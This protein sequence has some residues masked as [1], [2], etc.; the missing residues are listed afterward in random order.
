MSEQNN[1]IHVIQ[2]LM[3]IC[4]YIR[5]REDIT[6]YFGEMDLS[7]YKQNFF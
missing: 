1:F 2:E 5:L 6:V 7:S 4:Q 3:D